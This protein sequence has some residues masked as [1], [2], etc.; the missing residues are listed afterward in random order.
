VVRPS[1]RVISGTSARAHSTCKPNAEGVSPQ[2]A[3]P[4]VR[5]SPSARFNV[6]LTWPREQDRYE[7][8]RRD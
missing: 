1:L 7:F 6:I 8:A 5:F 4:D 2:T 3:I